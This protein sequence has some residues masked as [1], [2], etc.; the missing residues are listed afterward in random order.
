MPDAMPPPVGNYFTQQVDQ[1]HAARLTQADI[2]EAVGYFVF[3]YGAKIEQAQW[4]AQ[5]IAVLLWW[6]LHQL[7]ALTSVTGG[8]SLLGIGELLTLIRMSYQTFLKTLLA[9]IRLGTG[10]MGA[11]DGGFQGLQMLFGNRKHFDWASFEHAVLGGG[12]FGAS[13]AALKYLTSLAPMINLGEGLGLNVGQNIVTGCCCARQLCGV[14]E[15]DATSDPARHLG[16]DQRFPN[17]GRGEL[18]GSEPSPARCRRAAAYRLF[19][20]WKSFGCRAWLA[21]EAVVSN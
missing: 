1:I 14:S 9:N 15:Q 21:R 20:D 11:P 7:Y 3:D 5:L 17:D 10:L 8:A 12:I 4:T 16:A 18:S 13:L 6:Q 2:E 19:S